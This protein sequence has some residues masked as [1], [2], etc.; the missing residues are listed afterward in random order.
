MII[1][2]S[3]SLNML[4]TVKGEFLKRSIDVTEITIDEVIEKLTDPDLGGIESAIGHEDTA[5][6]FS[7]ELGLEIPFN[8][9]TISLNP[10]NG[11]VI[12][13]QYRGP[14]LPE[15]TTTLPEGAEICWY[16]VEIN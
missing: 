6:L 16:I 12:V 7:K 2:N 8:R 9:K 11:W 13:G 15:G 4:E 14:R 3:F 1:L 10:V 5:K